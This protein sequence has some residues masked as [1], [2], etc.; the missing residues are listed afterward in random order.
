MPDPLRRRHEENAND[1]PYV[2]RHRY[3][4][5]V[6]RDRRGRAPQPDQTRRADTAPPGLVRGDRG[7]RTDRGRRG[8]PLPGGDQGRVPPRRRLTGD[9]MDAM[10]SLPDDIADRIAGAPIS[11]GVCEVPGWGHQL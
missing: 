4:R 3:R 2:P 5:H 1:G 9:T 6:A 8:G 7:P 10:S 11:W